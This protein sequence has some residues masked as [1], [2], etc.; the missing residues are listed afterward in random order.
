MFRMQEQT[1]L[2][3][4]QPAEGAIF[5]SSTT[6]TIARTK[7]IHAVG[8]AALFLT[9]ALPPTSA[10]AQAAAGA[11]KPAVVLVHGAWADGS[12]WNSVIPLLLKAGYA[13]YAPPNPLRGWP[14]TPQPSRLSS[15]R[16][17]GR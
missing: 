16:S 4:P 5:M 3:L 1:T 7:L 12:S 8:A 9:L 6:D 10:R 11:S 14:P 13:V 15:S 17:R 2:R